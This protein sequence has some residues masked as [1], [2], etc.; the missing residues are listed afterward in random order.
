MWHR[1]LT[2][3]GGQSLVEY[4]LIVGLVSVGL[5]VALGAMK[6]QLLNVFNTAGAKMQQAA[7][8]AQSN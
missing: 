5:V 3:E 6:S 4:G 7:S 8:S 1:L 2:D